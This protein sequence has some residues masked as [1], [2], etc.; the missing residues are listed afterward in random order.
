M[1]Y[2][3][4][5]LNLQ[6]ACN[7]L[8]AQEQQFSAKIFNYGST[9]VTLA[10]M[11]IVTWL[12]ETGTEDEDAF[13]NTSG[14]V[15]GPGGTNCSNVNITNASTS[16]GASSICTSVSGH[17][18]NQS[19]TFTIGSG[20]TVVIPANGGY[21]QSQNDMFQFGRN[22]SQMDNG[23]WADDYSHIGTG[24]SCADGNFHDSPYYALLSNGHLVQEVTDTNGDLD[25]NTG[26][27]PCEAVYCITSPVPT[28]TPTKTPTN[29]PTFTKTSTATFT[30][31]KTPTSGAHGNIAGVL[32]L[33]TGPDGNTPT[34]T[35]TLTPT[36]T[37]TPVETATVTSMPTSSI[38]L[39]TAV[40]APNITRNGQPVNFM[41]N[42]GYNASIQLNLYT[43]MGEE[44][45]SDT[46][47]GN[48]G[49]NTITWLL[50][51]KAQS[52]VATGIYIYSIQVNN[53]YET[54]TKTGKV[55][56]FH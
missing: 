8:G 15:C 9:P 22:N 10:N 16:H 38:L 36:A 23:N 55:L 54:E 24:S 14:Q 33:L 31:T 11:S 7:G 42:L 3:G 18:A 48:A 41:I 45:Y 27:I 25:P 46:I 56:V 30:P 40:A 49:Q 19:V 50:K 2:T 29:S 13:A 37:I 17:F 1:P 26:L 53:G 43:I 47:E 28:A 4:P 20:D 34:S 6:I 12:Y 35:P 5:K 44:V 21:W 32:N 52:S 39:Q 51:N